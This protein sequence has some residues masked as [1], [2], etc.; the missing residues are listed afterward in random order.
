MVKQ[1][2]KFKDVIAGIGIGQL[3][4]VIIDKAGRSQFFLMLFSM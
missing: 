3:F 4:S 1:Q 2:V